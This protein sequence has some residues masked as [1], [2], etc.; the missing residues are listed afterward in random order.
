MSAGGANGGKRTLN[1]DAFNWRHLF[2]DS[3]GKTSMSLLVAFIFAIAA[4][5][6]FLWSIHA[7][8]NDGILG[9]ISFAGVAGT[10]LGIRRYTKDEPVDP[11]A[12]GDPAPIINQVSATTTITS[13]TTPE[14]ETKPENQELS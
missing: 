3:Q 6:G 11:A 13:T 4:T 12:V 1:I 14:T 7:K 9:S 5:V 8:F 2:N 10:L